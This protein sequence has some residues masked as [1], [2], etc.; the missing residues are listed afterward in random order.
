MG[1]G[2]ARRNEDINKIWDNWDAIFSKK[3]KEE[4]KEVINEEK[5]VDSEGPETKESTETK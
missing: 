3:N 1:K 5:I 4:T 2:S